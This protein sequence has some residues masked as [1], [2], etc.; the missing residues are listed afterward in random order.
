MTFLIDAA[1]YYAAE[2]HQDA[3]WEWLWESLDPYTQQVFVDCYRDSPE[4][5]V[6][7]KPLSLIHI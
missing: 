5:P 7:P 2:P 6:T 1:K 3:A 4:P